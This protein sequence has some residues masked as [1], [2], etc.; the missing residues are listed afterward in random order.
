MPVA[1]GLDDLLAA[2][3]VGGANY[4]PT[5][6]APDQLHQ[7][8]QRRDPSSKINH[9]MIITAD[10]PSACHDTPKCRC[11]IGGRRGGLRRP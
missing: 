9:A 11:S 2:A 8:I 6:P 7:P 4:D 10:Q 1:L 5:E 3:S